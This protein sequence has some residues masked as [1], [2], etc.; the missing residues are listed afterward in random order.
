MLT[1]RIVVSENRS[2]C[3]NYFH[4]STGFELILVKIQV[5][6]KENFFL[7][8]SDG[9]ICEK[10]VYYPWTQNNLKLSVERLTLHTFIDQHIGYVGEV[11]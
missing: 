7:Y 6:M 10:A 1:D 2:R 11:V 8:D 5:E 9:V 4:C 3:G